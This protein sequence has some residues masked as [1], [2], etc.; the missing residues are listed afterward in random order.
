MFAWPDYLDLA[1]E[2]AEWN[3]N[4]A[5]ERSA[6]SRAYY[7]A[8]GMARGYLRGVG[9]SLPSG[10]R[11]HVAVWDHF[12]TTPNPVHRRIADRGR[13]LRRR[14]GRADYED[15]YPGVSLDAS[16]AVSLARRLLADLLKLP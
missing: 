13:Q 12:H 6:I 10:S 16:D 14:R 3:G 5:A 15:A 9:V 8:F 4:E 2:L 7:P 1:A 11:A